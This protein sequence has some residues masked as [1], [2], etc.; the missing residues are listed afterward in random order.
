MAREIEA[1]RPAPACPG[2]GDARGV[3]LWGDEK[4]AGWWCNRCCA[5]LS[6]LQAVKDTEARKQAARAAGKT[7]DRRKEGRT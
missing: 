5:W 6:L 1:D 4:A 2:H 7:A 3:I